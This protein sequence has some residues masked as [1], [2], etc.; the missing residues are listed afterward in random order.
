MSG[1]ND[2]KGANYD[3]LGLGVPKTDKGDRQE[4]GQ[5]QF[6]ELMIAQL[7]NQDPIKPLESNEFMAQVA[8]F[9]QVASVQSME[10]SISNLAQ[11]LQSSQALQASTMVGREVLVP[12]GNIRHEAGKATTGGIE[13]PASTGSLALEISKPSG[14]IVKRLELGHQSAGLVEFSWDGTDDSG[15][16]VGEGTYVLNARADFDGAQEAV[17]TYVRAKVD[18]VTLDAQSPELILNL[19][20][21]GTVSMDMVKQ[22]L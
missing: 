18:S 1:I 12:S 14:E 2:I 17:G 13:V 6:F 16:G 20:G 19:S 21:L 9:S 11:S 15:A 7:Q 22:I 4:L 3:D 8:Q 10:R 5:E